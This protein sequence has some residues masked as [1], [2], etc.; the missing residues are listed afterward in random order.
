MFEFFSVFLKGT[1]ASLQSQI[2]PFWKNLSVLA[3]KASFRL[4]FLWNTWYMI[5]DLP[6]K[7]SYLGKLWLKS[8]AQ[9]CP[10]EIIC[11]LLFG[12]VLWLVYAGF[13]LERKVIMIICPL[14]ISNIKGNSGS[15]FKDQNGSKKS[16]KLAKFKPQTQI[17]CLSDMFI[18]DED[19]PEIGC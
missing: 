8:W 2:S 14:A 19:K 10:I 13:D 3:I 12:K 4:P 5:I 15:Q 7:I 9:N 18:F 11:F 6:C 17:S 1:E 16:Q